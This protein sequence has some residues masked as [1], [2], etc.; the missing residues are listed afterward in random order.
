MAVTYFLGRRYWTKAFS[1][2]YLSVW[3]RFEPLHLC[4]SC[5]NI[6]VSNKP[7]SCL[8]PKEKKTSR[9]L[10]WLGIHISWT[11]K[12]L[13]CSSSFCFLIWSERWLILVWG[14]VKFNFSASWV[15]DDNT[16]SSFHG[17]S[18]GEELYWLPAIRRNRLRN[19]LEFLGS[20]QFSERHNGLLF[21]FL[22]Y[23]LMRRYKWMRS[24]WIFL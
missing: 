9:I 7:R 13:F 22:M 19:Y 15:G 21:L 24:W 12:L 11:Q 14:W 8:K 16:F 6:H 17:R 1:K 4:C 5:V 10:V 20:K 18:L 3:N 2:Q 23:F